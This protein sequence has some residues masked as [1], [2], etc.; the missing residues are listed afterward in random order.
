MARET[1]KSGYKAKL[2]RRLKRE[3]PDASIQHQ[4]PNATHQGIPDLKITI[5]DRWAMLEVKAAANSRKQPNQ[6]YW[7]DYYNQQSFASFI[8]PENEE[9]VFNALFTTFRL[10][11]NARNS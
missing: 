8:Y 4:D 10:E 7:I 2:V 6:D 1:G 3:F 11:R 5:G 9:E